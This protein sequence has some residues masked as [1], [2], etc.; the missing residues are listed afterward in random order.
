[1]FLPSI[2]SRRKRQAEASEPD[3]YTYDKIPKNVRI[4]VVQIIESIL[5]VSEVNNHGA[6]Q[7]NPCY[8]N[9]VKTI[10]REKDVHQLVE[11][12]ICNAKDDSFHGTSLRFNCTKPRR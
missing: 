3:V 9:I 4:Q 10:R 12:W 5:D 6:H 2:Y 8:N 7:Y 1:M 11:G